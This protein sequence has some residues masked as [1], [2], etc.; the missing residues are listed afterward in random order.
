[1]M[2]IVQPQSNV[3]K[4]KTHVPEL[5][6]TF[7]ARTASVIGNVKVGKR[8]YVWSG[9]IIRGLKQKYIVLLTLMF[10]YRRC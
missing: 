9:A 2:M 3:V 1:M 7:V 10:Y 6:D 5:N 8:S 4:Y